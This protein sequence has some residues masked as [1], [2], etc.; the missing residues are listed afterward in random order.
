VVYNHLGP[1]GNYLGDYGPY[2]TDRYRTP[3]GSAL[4]FDGPNSDHVRRFFVE[5]ALSWLRD[6]HVDGLRLD[7]VH[8]I[9]DFSAVPFLADLS[10]AA[11]R[12]STETGWRRILIAE[13]DLNDVRVLRERSRGGLGLDAQW[14]D[15]F[16]HSLHA[17]LTEEHSGYYSDFEGVVDL[18]TA[19]NEAYVYAGRL[20]AFRGRRHGNSAAGFLG[21]EF[22]VFAQNHDQVGNRMLGERFSALTDFERQ[23]LA[24]GALLL[25]PYLPMLFM[26]EEYGET[27]P[28][29]YFVSHSDAGLVQ[30]VREGRRREFERFKWKGEPPDPQA[31]ETCDLSKLRWSTRGE[32]RHAVLLDFYRTLLQL[33]AETPALSQLDRDGCRAE[34]DA[35]LKT[36]RL[37]RTCSGSGVL[38][39][40]NFSAQPQRVGAVPDGR[41]RRI[42][43]SADARF[44]GPGSLMP[45]L[46][47]AG[48]LLA[49][50]SIVLYGW[51]G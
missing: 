27:A 32:G 20:S 51:E 18:A 9:F 29:L 16:H 22:V 40:M 26:G 49:P 37:V 50:Y 44:Q 5:N 4:N 12:L 33:R 14:N 15:D 41:W 43:D 21:R 17:S 6:F 47:A 10:E 19:Y 25:A 34:S 2:F 39:F 1:E 46:P 35:A 30:A 42:L 13:S 38:A 48:A 23:K 24:A 8:G 36:L 45:D 3:W 11:D 7:A 31:Q 28:F